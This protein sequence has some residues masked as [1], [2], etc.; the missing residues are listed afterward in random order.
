[1]KT[2]KELEADISR[3]MDLGTPPNMLNGKV[4]HIMI[5]KDFVELID[6]LEAREGTFINKQELKARING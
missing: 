4:K 3:F 6:D 1:M 5:L 2:I